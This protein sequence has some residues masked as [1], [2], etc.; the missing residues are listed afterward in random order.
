MKQWLQNKA[1]RKNKGLFVVF[2]GGDGSGKSTQS[3]MLE[4][5]LKNLGFAV[6]LTRE[7]GGTG[8]G[9]AMREILLNREELM[10]TKKAEMFLFLADRAQHVET[11]I[12]P[13][14]DAG[15]IVICDRYEAS[16]IAYQ[17]FASGLDRGILEQFSAYAAGSLKPDVVLFLDVPVELGL[18][19]AKLIDRNRFE[20]QAIDY[21][22]KVR[23][24]YL[25][26]ADKSWVMI[27]GTYNADRVHG[28]I[29]MSMMGILEDFTSQRLHP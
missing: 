2:E 29:Y 15:R 20:D 25:A 18:E 23:E 7:P 19:R 21:H 4:H 14:L 10:L 17:S 27:D 9:L 6:T 12:R 16:T 1:L 13:A 11:V 3:K 22:L 24:G 28:A 5:T 8:A 26:Q